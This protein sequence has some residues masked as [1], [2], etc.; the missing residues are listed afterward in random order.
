[1]RKKH[2]NQAVASAACVEVQTT[3]GTQV[4]VSAA[5]VVVVVLLLTT[6]LTARGM[7]VQTVVTTLA[8]AGLLGIELVR[9]LVEAL[10]AR[11][12]R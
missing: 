7:A 10:T 1:M 8:T 9:R 3:A 12:T 5:I 11:R 2:T 6:A 4:P